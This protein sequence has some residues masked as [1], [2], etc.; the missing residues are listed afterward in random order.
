VA[1]ERFVVAMRIHRSKNSG[2]SL[3]A[4]SAS[5][6]RAIT[7][8]LYIFLNLNKQISNILRHICLNLLGEK[9]TPYFFLAKTFYVRILFAD[10][11]TSTI[12]ISGGIYYRDIEPKNDVTDFD[13][14]ASL[15]FYKF[16]KIRMV[17]FATF[18]KEKAISQKLKQKQ[19][20]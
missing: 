5:N 11:L 16:S 18:S 3:F 20:F 12:L 1:I 17:A 19:K 8:K 10:A 2:F 7:N 6:I 15:F 4:L 14:S 13:F 9:V